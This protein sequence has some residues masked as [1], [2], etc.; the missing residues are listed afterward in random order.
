MYHTYNVKNMPKICNPNPVNDSRI[1]KRKKHAP[2][3][4]SERK[5]REICTEKTSV[6]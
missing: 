3:A 2:K 5:Q 4:N 1:N 6:L